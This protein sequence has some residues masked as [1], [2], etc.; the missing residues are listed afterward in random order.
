MS[1][2]LFHVI[3]GEEGSCLY[4]FSG[5]TQLPTGKSS[6]S[7][8]F[9]KKSDWSPFLLIKPLPPTLSPTSLQCSQNLNSIES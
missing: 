1:V 4:S 2:K 9:P 8:H 6:G 5:R 7:L 3:M